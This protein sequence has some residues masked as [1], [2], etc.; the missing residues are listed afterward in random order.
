MPKPE[1]IDEEGIGA[2]F[3]ETWLIRDVPMREARRLRYD[4]HRIAEAVSG[5]AA[6]A[7]DFDRLAHAV[8]DGYNQDEWDE[9]YALTSVEREV[10]DE[11]LSAETDTLDSLE[12][13]VAGLVYALATVRIIPAASCRGHPGDR[14]WSDSPVV[15]FAT[16]EFRARALQ[17]LVEATGCRFGIDTARPEL[18]AVAGRSILDTMALADA[19]LRSRHTFVQ[20]RLPRR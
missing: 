16:T 8:E 13:G 4:E 14:A 10:L 12:L 18:L 3:R 17:P 7:G 11:F 6:T 1:D 2:F 9:N 5:L 20:K 19:V 15:L